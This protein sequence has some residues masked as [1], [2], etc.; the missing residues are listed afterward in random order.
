MD[1]SE[2]DAIKR[3]LAE[4]LAAQ[5]EVRKI[6][7]FGSFLRDVEPHDIDVA[8]FQDSN[9]GYLPLALRYRRAARVVARNIPLDILPLR[10]GVQGVFLDE[11]AAGEVIYER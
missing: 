7:V 10:A 3:Q 4:C 5:R 6:V 2:K 8:V 11:I 1:N 9:E